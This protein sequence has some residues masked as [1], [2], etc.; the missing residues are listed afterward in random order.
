[1]K[2]VTRSVLRK[3]SRMKLRTVAISLVIAV[4][5]AMFVAGF[6]GSAVMDATVQSF[7]K[8]NKMP[9]VFL[10]FSKPVNETEVENTLLSSQD[11]KEYDLRLKQMGI[12]N[13]NGEDISVIFIGIK[14]PNNDKINKLGLESGN[15]FSE[16]NEAVAV[17]GMEDYKI[18]K[19]E[20]VQFDLSGK[21]LNLTISGTVTSPEYIFTSDFSDYSIPVSGSLIVIYMHLED[22]QDVSTPGINDVIVIV[23][24]GGSEGNVVKALEGFEIKTVTI[25]DSHPSVIFMNIASGKLKSMFPLMGAI[26]MF[27]G[28]ISIFMTVMRLVQNDSRY[29]GVL[30][31]HGYKRSEIVRSYLVMGL[32]ITII[33]CII[34]VLLGLF[35]A[36]SFVDVGLAL[37]FKV[38]IVFPFTLEPFILGIL[39]TM[40]VVMFSVWVPIHLITRASVREAL[41]YKPR[42]KVKTS[43]MLGGKT[44]RVTM[45]GFRN[46]T[47]NPGRLAITVFVIALTIG[48][49]GSWVV[50]IDSAFGYMKDQVEADT[51]DMRADF[52]TPQQ[53]ASVNASFLDI[54][55]SDAEYIIP[56]SFLMGEITTG[57][58][59]ESTTIIGCDELKTVREFEVRNGNLDFNK[60]VLT[61]KLADD[62]GVSPG[63]EVKL[64]FGTE[65]LKFEVSAIVYDAILHS[66]YTTRSN[67][68]S[69]YPE[70]N[71]SGAYIKLTNPGT[72][73]EIAKDMR[74]LPHVSK[75][76]VHSDIIKTFDELIEMAR[77]FLIT[78]F[79][80]NI[81]ITIVVASS[82]V[83]ISTMERD[84]EFATLD[85]L[86]I[87]RWQ[88][89][90]S[91]LV[92]M[93]LMAVM[94]SALGIPFAYLF[95]DLMARVLED[96]IFYF[97]V[98]L[99]IG[100]TILTFVMG[101]VFILFSSIVPIRYS[102]KL[103]TEKTIRERTAG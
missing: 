91:I 72:A 8:N 74:T 100:G 50:M 12:Y 4:A 63:D 45:L 10:E 25:Q 76:V 93:A 27:I 87:S 56:F 95:A 54:N 46:T 75:V 6:Y 69:I 32:I 98:V 38:D 9:D 61:N 41:E 70:A 62:L 5:M 48:V 28:F 84:V 47:R 101:I 66:L 39:Y 73:D 20:H 58:N 30:M 94:A 7:F 97:P 33:G 21:A 42:I 13:Y 3:L 15:L 80:L 52:S 23:K 57:N 65:E 11:V 53:S 60:A 68:G 24:D 82:A 1:M 90:K 22:L 14:N 85:T 99:A 86:G 26:F 81:L 51:W 35:F 18:K 92:E 36:H 49:A 79:F 31:A 43:K 37:Y 103:D 59:R 102:G 96:V 2:V 78:F 29:I 64:I 16:N 40:A 71:C 19:G 44:S 88:V 89:A 17:S 83:I 67:I 34:G 77:G 55:E